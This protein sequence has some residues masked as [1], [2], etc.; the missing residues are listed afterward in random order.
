[1]I[2]QIRKP[3]KTQPFIH[4]GSLGFHYFPDTL[5]YTE[6]DLQQWLPV[7]LELGANWL[8]IRSDTARAIPETFITTLKQAGISPFIQFHMPLGRIPGSDEI[9]PLIS[10]Y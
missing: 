9:S 10:A 8:V 6:R 7:L 2:D 3:A 1:M 5:H 4:A